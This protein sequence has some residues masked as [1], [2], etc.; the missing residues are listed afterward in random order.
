MVISAAAT[1]RR[2]RLFV[3]YAHIDMDYTQKLCEHLASHNLPIWSDRHLVWGEDFV[4]GIERII[5]E[6]CGIIVVMSPASA[7]SRF[8]RQ[9]I[10]EGLVRGRRFLPI[11]LGGE[12]LFLLR[13]STYFDAMGGTTLPGDEE[14]HRLRSACGPGGATPV[15][16]P[17]RRPLP[18][19]PSAPPDFS[20]PPEPSPPVPPP[21]SDDPDPGRMTAVEELVDHLAHGRF[22]HADLVTTSMLLD[23]VSRLS[24]GWMRIQDGARLPLPLLK[25]IDRVWR[26]ASRGRFGFSRQVAIRGRRPTGVRDFFPLADAL[27]WRLDSREV[28]PRYG[29][30][31]AQARYPAGYPDGFFPTL[32]N[33]Q[34]EEGMGWLKQWS[35]SVMA[36]HLRLR[37]EGELW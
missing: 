16:P 25:R 29:E 9:E 24:A 20:R 35:Q 30:F 18:L 10:L 37:G 19:I 22:G 17:G 8:V 32:R 2:P 31:L 15:R 11:L 26:E 33:A 5:Q 23:P 28:I 7:R 3:S 4:D 21:A 6:A 13:S 36:T 14:I 1:R 27:K 12:P 34:I